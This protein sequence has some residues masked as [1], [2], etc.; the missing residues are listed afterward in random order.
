MENRERQRVYVVKMQSLGTYNKNIFIS[1]KI[2]F[3]VTGRLGSA[4]PYKQSMKAVG[5]L[6]GDLENT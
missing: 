2:K 5:M 4:P 6:R 1:E 3:N